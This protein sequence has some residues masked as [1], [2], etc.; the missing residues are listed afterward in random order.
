VPWFLPALA[1]TATLA[2]ARKVISRY[3][4]GQLAQHAQTDPPGLRTVARFTIEQPGAIL[5]ALAADLR[6][7]LELEVTKDAIRARPE[8]EAAL[9]DVVRLARRDAHT[10]TLELTRAWTGVYL[11]EQTKQIL[12]RLHRRIVALAPDVMWFARQD[13][14][15]ADPHPFP[16]DD[17]A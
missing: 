2:I 15:L 10:F 13:R 3:W 14:E 16:V 4:H 12:R 11:G 5:D 6:R 9:V 7:D 1:A 17:A 8:T